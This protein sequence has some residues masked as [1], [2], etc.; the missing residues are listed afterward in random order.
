MQLP[1]HAVVPNLMHPAIRVATRAFQHSPGLEDAYKVWEASVASLD[2][3]LVPFE[4]E[5]TQRDT[6]F[7]GARVLSVHSLACMFLLWPL[8]LLNRGLTHLQSLGLEL[9][10]CPDVLA[11]LSFFEG[12]RPNGGLGV[13]GIALVAG[14][15]E[16][17]EPPWSTLVQ[18]QLRLC[19][20]RQ[21]HLD[22]ESPFGGIWDVLLCRHDSLNDR[23]FLL[24]LSLLLDS[25]VSL[26]HAG[27]FF[28]TLV[29]RWLTSLS[30][31][32]REGIVPGFFQPLMASHP[33][34]VELM[35]EAVRHVHADWSPN[36][37][38][39]RDLQPLKTVVDAVLEQRRLGL[40]LPES[41]VSRAGVRL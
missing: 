24:T 11:G 9:G 10:A 33:E 35:G 17:A 19:R 38:K 2:G 8:P 31:E 28:Q 23:D 3:L 36:E 7:E 14:R 41:Q 13:S 6:G 15:P 25:G 21:D 18:S 30:P 4:I 5:K 32:E 34:T 12:H 26:D 29:S 39:L 40:T 20:L 37:S 22:R 16:R 27:P 1:Q